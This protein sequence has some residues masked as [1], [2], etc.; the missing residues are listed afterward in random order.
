MFK[1]GKT[2]AVSG[3]TASV[4]S[5]SA[6]AQV[7]TVPEPYKFVPK[8]SL[9]NIDIKNSDIAWEVV[10]K[11]KSLS[12]INLFAELGKD[13]EASFIKLLFD[14]ANRKNFGENFV[15]SLFDFDF[16]KEKTPAFII[17]EEMKSNESVKIFKNKVNELAKTKKE[18]KRQ[19][20]KLKDAEIISFI[21]T[22]KVPDDMNGYHF[23]MVNNFIIASN[24]KESVMK[25]LEAFYDQSLSITSLSD[26][27]KSY[28]KVGSDFQIQFH[29]NNKK[30]FSTIYDSKEM[31][32]AFKDMNFNYEEL[33][34]SNLSLFNFRMNPKSVDI[35]SYSTI[36]KNNK[37]GKLSLDVKPSNFKKFIKMSPKNTLFFIS[38][39]DSEKAG[40]ALTYSLPKMKDLNYE[41]IIIDA[42]G[43]NLLDAM[44][45]IE[46]D[47]AVSVFS[48]ESS[49]IPGFAIMLTPKDSAKMVEMLNSIKIKLDTNAKDKGKRNEKANKAPIEF[50]FTNKAMYKDVEIFST[51][52]IQ[53]LAQANIQPAYGFINKDMI[54]ASNS[55][56]L[57]SIVDRNN[58]PSTDY[59]L[60]GN[61]SFST[62][63]KEFGEMNAN[64]GFINLNTIVN[65]VSPFIQGNKDLKDT[66]TQLKK[67]DAIGFN[68]VNDTEGSLGKFVLLADIEN[69]D[70]GKI[71][72]PD[73]TKGFNDGFSSGADRAKVSSV[74]ANMHTVQVIAETH[75]VD[76]SGLYPATLEE[77][78]K[79]SKSTKTHSNYYKSI[80]NPFTK[81]SGVAS[82]GSM[83][84]YSTYNALKNKS[85]SL[86]GLVVYQASNCKIDKATKRS[87][88]SSYKI[89]G[90][91][92][93]GKIIQDKGKNFYLTNQ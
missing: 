36:D 57:K 59:T 4:F 8:E 83:I 29:L 79:E 67:F 31:K 70:F 44:K 2:L 37:M 55:E 81:K 24:T 89:Y 28:E 41:Q 45:N 77:I 27:S 42:I 46:D 20:S 40:E 38:S 50:K 63:S 14:D 53:D 86:K 92:S 88:C 10:K 19:D 90:L 93:K 13:K 30:F 91:D 74:K 78:E 52:E 51:N 12:K 84:N 85:E 58:T 80:I 5:L 1:F 75:A 34:T 21:S 82:K 65:M 64:L 35:L 33:M 23:A 72:P 22:K 43:V 62:L 61:Q 11:N 7:I 48:N 18:F 17:I 39:S 56:I 25:S 71:I 26:F 66:L 76:W 9:M 54:L 15:V 16:E 47:F 87:L 73:I 32:K 68:R 6:L 49:P 69:M 3:I 60:E